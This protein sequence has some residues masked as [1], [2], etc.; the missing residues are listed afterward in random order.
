MDAMHKKKILKDIMRS[1]DLHLQFRISP[2]LLLRLS[3]NTHG[4]FMFYQVVSVIKDEMR[5]D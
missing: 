2:V 1:I 3:F 5:Q 4:P